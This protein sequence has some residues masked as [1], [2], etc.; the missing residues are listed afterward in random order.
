MKQCRRC[1]AQRPATDFHRSSKTKDGLQGYCRSCMAAAAKKWRAQ[2]GYAE[3]YAA[4]RRASL[5]GRLAFRSVERDSDGERYLLAVA[6]DP[7]AYCGA[8][9]SEIDHVVPGVDDVENFAAACRTCNARKGERSLLGWLL[10]R[11][12]LAGGLDD[13]REQW[14]LAA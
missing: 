9:A 2:S 14:R 10:R 13:M 8:P 5:R 7:C 12:L 11:S 4:S 1:G 6:R 3:T